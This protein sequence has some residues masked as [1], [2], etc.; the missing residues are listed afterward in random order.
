MSQEFGCLN[1]PMDDS[2]TTFHRFCAK[3]EQ[4]LYLGLKDKSLFGKKRSYWDYILRGLV[5]NKGGI[6]E[7]L[8]FVK[9]N[10]ECL[11]DT[12]QQCVLGAGDMSKEWFE[13]WA[14]MRNENAVKQLI[15]ALYDL[16]P[17]Q[18]DL[19][20]PSCHDLD[21]SWPTFNR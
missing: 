6:H 8:K 17:V 20:S 10:T 3:L 12:L 18:F 4:F 21:Q 5:S 7:G 1:I 11:A 16:N 2:C 14:P 19:S 9:N 13:E 15:A